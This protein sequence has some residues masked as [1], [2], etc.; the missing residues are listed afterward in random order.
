MTASASAA[1]TIALREAQTGFIGLL[2][3][4]MLSAD[5]HPDLYNYASRQLPKISA[6]AGR[7]EYR[8]TR[9]GRVLRLHRVPIDREVV[10]P[11][12][13]L[14]KPS[15]RTLVLVM[16]AAA[17]LEDSE[18]TTTLQQI[19]D[20]VRAL[21]ARD[22]NR[23][24][25]FDPHMDSSAERHKLRQAA[26]ILEGLGVLRRVTNEGLLD[27][28]AESGAGI[29]AGYAVAREALLALTDPQVVSAT[30]GALRQPTAATSDGEGPVERDTDL[31][32]ATDP[33]ADATGLHTSKAEAAVPAPRPSTRAR[34]L[35]RLIETPFV[36]FADLE[37][38]DLE[39][40]RTQQSAVIAV[41]EEMTGGTVEMRSEGMALFMD[42]ATDQTAVTTVDWPSGTSA[43]WIALA[44]VDH[45]CSEALSSRR[46]KGPAGT[47][48]IPADDV[49]SYA[50]K[51]DTE[52]SQMLVK[53]HRGRTDL[54]AGVARRQ[55]VAAGLVRADLHGNW[56]LLPV[57]ARYRDPAVKTK[58]G[59][60][61]L[62]E[63]PAPD[64]SK[65]LYTDDTEE[66]E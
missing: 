40:L 33:A 14:E 17:A 6:W 39:Y 9:V 53:T 44:Y 34:L 25:P 55:L 38:A 15:R 36:A 37:T 30:L 13:P 4:P 47:V 61:S 65:G 21:S 31:R 64:S 48:V 8:V 32:D 10:V 42:P 54:I 29:G 3:A 7:L 60:A 24:E 41:V 46:H 27:A 19:A 43:S 45:F 52:Y 59:I 51:L 57:A 62:F 63:A 23:V 22:D 35:R 12:A 66:F 1:E 20:R 28:W 2:V 58:A 56:T 26:G 11:P 16:V 49:T 18:A 5:Q 50:E